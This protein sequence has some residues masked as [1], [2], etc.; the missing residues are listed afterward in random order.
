MGEESIT[1][2]SFL[3]AIKDLYA[4]KDEYIERMQKSELLDA[5]P[6]IVD[7]IDTI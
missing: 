4:R 1:P 2:D 7:L 6:K 3:E 5:I